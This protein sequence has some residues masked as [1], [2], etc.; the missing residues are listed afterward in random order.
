MYKSKN[1][2]ENFFTNLFILFLFVDIFFQRNLMAQDNGIIIYLRSAFQALLLCLG[3]CYFFVGQHVFRKLKIN[4]TLVVFI[5]ISSISFLITLLTEDELNLRYLIGDLYKF[6]Y[7]PL[8]VLLAINTIK[9]RDAS[10]KILQYF[11]YLM[12]LF[13]LKEIVYIEFINAERVV[14]VTTYLI[15]LS[16]TLWVYNNNIITSLYKRNLLSLIIVFGGLYLILSAQSLS[17]LVVLLMLF[18][19]SRWYISHSVIK[20]SLDFFLVLMVFLISLAYLYGDGGYIAMKFDNLGNANSV[21]EKIVI[22]SGD[23]IFYTISVFFREMSFYQFI[24][25]GMGKE[26][27][28]IGYE[29]LNIPLSN[30]WDEARHFIENGYSEVMYR[31]GALGLVSYFLIFFYMLRRATWVLKTEISP[32]VRSIV[33]AYSAYTMII[34]TFSIFFIGFPTDGF[35]TPVMVAIT[36]ASIFN[37]KAAHYE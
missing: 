28:I 16:I 12:S 14:A 11:F 8:I 35:Y 9:S 10:K 23:R 6:L 20:T 32:E 3:Y 4:A 31:V 36:A 27:V 13:I 2:S 21:L 25:G 24:F 22:L 7:F 33:G 17:L 19:G 29:E 37:Q 5:A 34:I 30:K 18:I 26:L 15:P 1:K